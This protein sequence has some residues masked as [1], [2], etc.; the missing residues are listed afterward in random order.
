VSNTV[1][2]KT[3]QN[4]LEWRLA[5]HYSFWYFTSKARRQHK[6]FQG[7]DRNFFCVEQKVINSL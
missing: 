5:S 2:T 1:F 3:A 7:R 4:Q 6:D